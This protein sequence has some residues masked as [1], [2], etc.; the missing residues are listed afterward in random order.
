MHFFFHLIE[1]YMAYA[2]AYNNYKY[3]NI[4]DLNEPNYILSNAI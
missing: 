4:D 3:F 2:Y 1:V